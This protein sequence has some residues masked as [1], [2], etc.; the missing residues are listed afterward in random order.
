[1]VLRT[2]IHITKLN[3]HQLVGGARSP[4]KVNGMSILG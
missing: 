1:M 2:I 3:F 4:V